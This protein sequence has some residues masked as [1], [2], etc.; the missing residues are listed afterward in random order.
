VRV[1][2]VPVDQDALLRA[3]RAGEREVHTAWHDVR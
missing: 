1:T 2:S 3:I